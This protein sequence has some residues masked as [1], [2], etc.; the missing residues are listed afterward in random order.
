MMDAH[1]LVQI[2]QIAALK[3]PEAI[4]NTHKSTPPHPPE[5]VLLQNSRRSDGVKKPLNQKIIQIR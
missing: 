2:G 1:A 5:G 3:F 4:N